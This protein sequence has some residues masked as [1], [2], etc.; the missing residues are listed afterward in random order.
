MAGKE[1]DSVILGKKVSAFL[2]A[3]LTPPWSE[4]TMCPWI[5]IVVTVDFI[6]LRVVSIMSMSWIR[7]LGEY[8]FRTTTWREEKEKVVGSMRRQLRLNVVIGWRSFSTE[9]SSFHL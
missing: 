5:Q 9:L 8:E 1:W 6:E 4:K 3:R 2:G 7:L